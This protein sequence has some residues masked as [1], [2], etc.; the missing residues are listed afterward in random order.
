MMVVG[1]GVYN[2]IPGDNVELFSVVWSYTIADRQGPENRTN[3]CLS[4]TQGKYLDI[5]LD[6]EIKVLKNQV[7]TIAIRYTGV[8]DDIG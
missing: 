5:Y 1:F 3:F 6:K 2:I 4:K 8:G 7:L